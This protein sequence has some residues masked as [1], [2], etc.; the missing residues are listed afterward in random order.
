MNCLDLSA[1]LDLC[2][3][4]LGME[5]RDVAHNKIIRG[6][7][8]GIGEIYGSWGLILEKF[9]LSRSQLVSS[10]FLLPLITSYYL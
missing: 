1:D 8:E 5:R 3:L 7:E 6:T 9:L 4:G 10:K 2:F